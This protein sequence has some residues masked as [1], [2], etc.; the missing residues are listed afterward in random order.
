M[1]IAYSDI[2]K[3]YPVLLTIYFYLALWEPEC[4]DYQYT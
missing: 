2:L 3:L 1:I 4:G